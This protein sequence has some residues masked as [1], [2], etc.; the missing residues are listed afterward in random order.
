MSKNGIGCAQPIA[1]P[2][3]AISGIIAPKTAC[4]P[5]LPSMS[6]MYRIGRRHMSFMAWR[7][8]KRH[9]KRRRQSPNMVSE[10][11]VRL[12]AVDQVMLTP[13]VQRLLNCDTLTLIDWGYTPVHGGSAKV[14]G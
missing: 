12:G 11:E 9:C 14:V 6:W 3:Q 10:F 7:S 2:T 5:V 8:I 13:I 4:R 1:K